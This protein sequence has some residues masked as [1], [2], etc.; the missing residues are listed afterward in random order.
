MQLQF[1]TE[2]IV[3]SISRFEEHML[4]TN[5]LAKKY[6]LGGKAIFTVRNE[7]TR[8]RFTYKFK[9]AKKNDK[10]WWVFVLT[11]TDNEHDYKFIGAFSHEKGYIH[12]PKSGITPAA[13]SVKVIAWYT[14]WLFK[15]QLPAFIKTYH[16]NHCGRC[17]R[18][19]TV[20]E[21]VISGFGPECIKMFSAS[22]HYHN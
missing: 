1:S 5:E 21:S 11:G 15:N 10:L 13:T 17:G 16:L 19:L 18:A 4:E 6:I 7:D 22:V 20:P 8:N 9:Q 12:S 2:Q 14:Y 3:P